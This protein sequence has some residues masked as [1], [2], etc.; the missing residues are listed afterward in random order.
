MGAKGD[1]GVKWVKFLPV[2][3]N[4]TMNSDYITLHFLQGMF[5]VSVKAFLFSITVF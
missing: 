1:T 5:D 3:M 4:I 2:Y